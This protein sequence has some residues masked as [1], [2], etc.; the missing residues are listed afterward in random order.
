MVILERLQ[1]EHR[2]WQ[3]CSSDGARE[4]LHN[5]MPLLNHGRIHVV[6][7]CV[8][9]GIVNGRTFVRREV[10]TITHPLNEV[11][12]TASTSVHIRRVH[13]RRVANNRQETS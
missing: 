9:L 6:I 3:A 13:A 1:K 10:K 2:V 8:L 7:P 11:E 5:G 4:G 12:I